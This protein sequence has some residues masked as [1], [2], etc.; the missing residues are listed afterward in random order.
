MSDIYLEGTPEFNRG[1]RQNLNGAAMDPDQAHPIDKELLAMKTIEQYSGLETTL[2]HE[3]AAYEMGLALGE[4][5]L[6]GE[7]NQFE[8]DM[9]A[10]V[11]ILGNVATNAL[12]ELDRLRD[13]S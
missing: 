4:F 9:I 3:T 11:S 10:T 6:A 8:A 12:N 2:G 13:G 5:V 1:F 7:L